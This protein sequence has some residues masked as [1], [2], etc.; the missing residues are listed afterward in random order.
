MALYKREIR[1]RVYQES[2][3]AD[4]TIDENSAE[5]TFRIRHAC[6]AGHDGRKAETGASFRIRIVSRSSSML[7]L[8]KEV[9]WDEALDYI[10][11]KG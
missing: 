3:Q 1:I 8:F 4:E 5:S 10:A 11:R 7:R 9:E 6:S 2:G